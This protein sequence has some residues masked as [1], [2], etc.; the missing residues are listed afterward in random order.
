MEADV[1]IVEDAM[2]A[3]DRSR[4]EAEQALVEWRSAQSS[5]LRDFL[6]AEAAI[7]AKTQYEVTLSLGVNAQTFKAKTMRA[8]EEAASALD[9]WASSLTV[10]QIL[11]MPGNLQEALQREVVEASTP[12]AVLLRGAGFDAG[13]PRGR[14]Y[15]GGREHHPWQFYNPA[16]GTAR[17]ERFPT[18]EAFRN[19][20]EALHR[21]SESI[22]GVAAAEQSR[23]VQAAAELWGD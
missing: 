6:I 11:T 22:R 21:Y 3:R 18:G 5:E 17:S 12:W 1:G 20:S 2:A 23:D 19:L 14:D 8:A 9:R 16:T 4:V 10:D 7:A 13:T 15:R